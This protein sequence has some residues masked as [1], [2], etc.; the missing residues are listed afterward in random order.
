[1]FQNRSYYVNFYSHAM[2][3]VT[4]S[5]SINLNVNNYLV[6][7]SFFRAIIVCWFIVTTSA[8][9]V[10]FSHGIIEFYNHK[11]EVNNAC[12]FLTEEGYNHAAFQVILDKA[13]TNYLWMKRGSDD[14]Q[15]TLSPWVKAFHG[16]SRIRVSV[17]SG[18]GNWNKFI[19]EHKI[20]ILVWKALL[21][22][23]YLFADLL[24]PQFLHHSIDTDFHSLR[25]YA[26]SSMAQRA[27]Q[28]SIRWIA[29][30]ET[31]GHTDGSFRCFG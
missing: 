23:F 12:L 31:K 22:A 21:N 24:L 3:R 30:R 20:Y 29:S 5:C 7:F 18:W 8:I 25:W 9:P 16:P 11:N 15:I 10:L 2:E 14:I 6:F 13:K 1:M 26:H 28:Q 19:S 27:G 17:F 4:V